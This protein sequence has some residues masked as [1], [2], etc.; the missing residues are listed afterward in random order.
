MLIW[1][2]TG[3][4]SNAV[5]DWR[6]TKFYGLNTNEDLVRL[7]IREDLNGF[8]LLG[9]PGGLYSDVTVQEREDG[10]KGFDLDITTETLV[11][12]PIEKETSGREFSCLNINDQ[13]YVFEEMP[14]I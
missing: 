2:L 8:L 12:D 5:G 3:C 13:P 7:I 14:E 9:A 1:F 6:A 4:L 11:C 10:K